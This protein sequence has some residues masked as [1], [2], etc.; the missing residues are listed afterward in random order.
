MLLDSWLTSSQEFYP[1]SLFFFQ[2]PNKKRSKNP[3]LPQKETKMWNSNHSIPMMLRDSIYPLR[4]LVFAP[5]LWSTSIFIQIH[6][7]TNLRPNKKWTC[8]FF[9]QKNKKQL[10]PKRKNEPTRKSPPPLAHQDF[11]GTCGTGANEASGSGLR[12]FRNAKKSLPETNG[13]H[14][15][16]CFFSQKEGRIFF[17]FASIFFQVR[18]VSF[19]ECIYH[20]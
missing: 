12:V 5:L 19:R 10:P 2:R 1:I 14:M 16:I 17:S 7:L 6:F 9:E 20:Q 15:K 18:A 13:L 4:S 11:I 3:I 8:F